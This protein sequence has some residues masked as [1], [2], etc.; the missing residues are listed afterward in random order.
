M[1]FSSHTDACK[2]RGVDPGA[3]KAEAPMN[4]QALQGGAPCNH[5]VQLTL[6]DTDISKSKLLKLGEVKPLE[7]SVG[8]VAIF[9]GD[10]TE[11]GR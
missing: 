8:E 2:A 7:V 3:T 11:G 1:T 4:V 9:D 10:N 5:A 6:R